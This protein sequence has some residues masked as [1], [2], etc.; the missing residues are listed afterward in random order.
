MLIIKYKYSEQKKDFVAEQK[1]KLKT[2]YYELSGI[3]CGKHLV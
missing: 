2:R 1:S 3:E